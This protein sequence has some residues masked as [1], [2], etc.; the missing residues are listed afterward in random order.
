MNL[1]TP[2]SQAFLDTQDFLVSPVTV[3]SQAFLVTPENLAT[4]VFQV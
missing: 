3:V 4:A 1:V 2:V